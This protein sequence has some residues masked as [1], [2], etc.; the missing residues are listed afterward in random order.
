MFSAC[1]E[2]SKYVAR[3]RPNSAG[4]YT[5]TRQCSLSHQLLPKEEQTK[6]EEVRLSSTYSNPITVLTINHRTTPT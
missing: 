1:A 2:H 5:E 4:Q 3:A 6:P